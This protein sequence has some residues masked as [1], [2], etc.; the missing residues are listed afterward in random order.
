MIMNSAKRVLIAALVAVS[1]AA[2]G[3]KHGGNLV[4]HYKAEMPKDTSAAVNNNPFAAGL[5]NAMIQSMTLDL[6]ADNTFK[7]SI[8]IAPV[9]GKWSEDGTTVT[10]TPTKVMGMDANQAANNTTANAA[11]GA[12]AKPM[13][14]TEQ[15][16]GTL[17]M[18]SDKPQ[19]Q[20]LVYRKDTSK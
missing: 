2:V 5:E 16:D 11:F 14:L 19:G 1:F 17:L 7:M 3:C 9:E 12:N 18:A 13:T 10:L 8:F 6:N 15:P 20:S 4:G